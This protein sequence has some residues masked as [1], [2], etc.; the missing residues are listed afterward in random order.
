MPAG[1]AILA[2]PPVTFA[3]AVPVALEL[4]PLE[5]HAAATKAAAAT[6]ATARRRSL[7]LPRCIFAPLSW[8][9]GARVVPF[10][11]LLGLRGTRA[12]AGRPWSARVVRA[13]RGGSRGVAPRARHRR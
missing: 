1:S 10:R 11:F 3:P 5:L 4:L 8:R 12:R 9:A 13:R 7:R 2:V 6:A